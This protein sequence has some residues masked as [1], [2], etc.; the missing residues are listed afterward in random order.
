MP[1]RSKA[2]QRFFALVRSYQ[3]GD[4]KKVSPAIK[5]VAKSI[6]K[7]DADDFASTKHNGLPS[8]VR[9]EIREILQEHI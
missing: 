9:Q 4:A 6:S 7:K 1:A 5:K 3:D 2:Q 8:K